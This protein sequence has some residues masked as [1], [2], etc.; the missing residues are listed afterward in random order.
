MARIGKK[1]H[2]EKYGIDYKYQP[3][4]KRKTKKY[5]SNKNIKMDINYITNN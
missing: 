3:K 1:K 4:T 5:K 2:I